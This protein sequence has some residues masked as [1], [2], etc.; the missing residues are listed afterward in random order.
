MKQYEDPEIMEQ[1][2]LI[3]QRELE[4]QHRELDQRDVYKRQL[5]SHRSGER[6]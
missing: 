6:G 2:L 3:K 1:F 4:E 5:S